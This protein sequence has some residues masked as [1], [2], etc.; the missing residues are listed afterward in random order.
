MVGGAAVPPTVC[1]IPPLER[2]Q[3]WT[4]WRPLNYFGSVSDKHYTSSGLNPQPDPAMGT[5]KIAREQVALA[6]TAGSSMPRMSAKSK[7]PE[8]TPS[9]NAML[10]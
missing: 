5:C 8:N 7:L 3:R 10:S 9:R 2:G 4:F 1:E 6:E